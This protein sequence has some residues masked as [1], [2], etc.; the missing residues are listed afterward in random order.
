ML[1]SLSCSDR[2][3]VGGQ[4]TPWAFAIARRLAIDAARGERRQRV[5]RSES[6][7]EQR[8]P[9]SADARA[10]DL[11]DAWRLASRLERQLNRLPESQ[12]EAF[13]LVRLEGLSLF[14]AAR[15]L[16]TTVGAVKLRLHRAYLA[17]RAVLG[18]APL[19]TEGG[20]K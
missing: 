16:G 4:V 10:D 11:L 12:R 20:A 1:R 15:V 6:C 13:E 9:T 14:E 8:D 19:P 7:S 3:M 2:F 5:D 17:L 18:P